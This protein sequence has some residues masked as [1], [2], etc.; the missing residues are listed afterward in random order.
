MLSL[1]FRLQ[2]FLAGILLSVAVSSN[3]QLCPPNIDFERGT[4]DGWTC[5]TGN[6]T[7]NGVNI[8]SLTP[9]GGPVPDRHTLF[10]ASSAGE[11]DPYGGFPVNCP[12]GS[13]YSIKLGNSSGGGMAEG[14]SYEFTIPT[15]ENYYTMIYNYAVVFQDPNHQEYEQPRM[16]IEITNVSDNQIIYCSSFT[17]IPFGTILPGFFQS[18]NPGSETPVWCKDWTAVSINLDGHAGKTI[19]LSFKTADCT[20]RRHFGYAYIDVNSECSGTFV[21]AA[22]CPDDTVVNVVAP[23]GYQNYTW[24]N[25]NFTQVIGNSQVLSLKPIPPPGTRVAV[26]VIPYNGYGCP[27]TLYAELLDTLTVTAHAGI[28]TISCNKAFVQIGS[29]PRAGLSY[30]WSP[31]TGLTNPNISN[32]YAAP[33][34][35][36]TYVVW[37]SHDGGG[38]VDT[39]TVT[40]KA[41]IIDNRIE[42]LGK[43]RLCLGTNDSAVLK[44]A[45]TDRIQWYRDGVPIPGATGTIHRVVESGV[46]HAMLYNQMGCELP[47]E[48]KTVFIA[49]IPVAGMNPV[50]LNQCLVGNRFNMIN[51]STNVLGEMQYM[52]ILG[53][54][55]VSSTRDISHSYAQAG[56]YDVKLVVT[57]NEICKDSLN[58]HVVIYQ[59]AI[60]DF[61]ADPICVNLPMLAVNNTVDTMGSPINY[62]WD[63]GNGITSVVRN[64]PAQIYPNP[65]T[66]AVSLSVN[67]EQ[68]PTPYN[69]M[70]KYI[71]VDKPRAAVNYPVEYAVVDLPLTLEAR[72]FGVSAFWSPGTFLN[73]Q[74][75]YTP[76]FQGSRDQTYTIKI[77]TVS[78]C[79]TVDT[80]V[81]KSVK[82]VEIYVPSAF[83]PNNDGKND[84]LKPILMGIKELKYFR[85]FNRWGQMIF[86]GRTV[87]PGWDGTVSGTPQGAD[88]FVWMVEGL[89]LD[90][91]TY[92]RKGTVTLVR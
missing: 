57:S 72:T 75:S 22:F 42:L 82:S 11:L 60:A 5:Y 50:T 49:S 1:Q 77:T 54:G 91:K 88:V 55:N 24:Y 67:T 83:T 84:R 2:L 70:K 28:D 30:R 33:D 59:N 7:G 51:T 43:E 89:G 71:V 64:P 17:F 66:F 27:D 92:R 29:P 36:T 4:F 69:T 9:S 6:V 58:F 68:C 26:E 21:G 86:D 14:I 37:V 35:T 73:T 25:N 32:P 19:R 44:V 85:V 53:D 56:N 62:I 45:P 13:G 87:E 12:N 46:Y 65:G 61:N 40:V 79:V 10:A 74:D 47:T 31:A 38:C 15:N 90:N 34:I 78:G 23:Y 16:E 80:Q 76:V 41:G 20:F 81:I 39:D 18:N 3:A 8:I 48:K 52:W 63:F